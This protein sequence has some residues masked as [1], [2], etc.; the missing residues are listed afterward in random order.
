M[1]SVPPFVVG[2]VVA[3]FLIGAG[4]GATM[5]LEAAVLGAGLLVGG[6]LVSCLLCWWLLGFEAPWWQLLLVALFTNPTFVVALGTALFDFGCIVGTKRGW[7]CLL[8][9]IAII[10]GGGALPTPLGGLF[11]RWWKRRGP[12]PATPQ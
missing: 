3:A 5:D 7:D 11:W 9:A 6:A 4:A 8:A 12:A 1:R 2:Y 10:I